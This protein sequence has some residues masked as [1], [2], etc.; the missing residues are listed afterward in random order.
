MKIIM[1][2]V[3]PHK[4]GTH[5]YLCPYNLEFGEKEKKDK[6]TEEVSTSEDQLRVEPLR[7]GSF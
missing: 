1:Q 4:V 3:Y 2:V 6:E 7:K 5:F